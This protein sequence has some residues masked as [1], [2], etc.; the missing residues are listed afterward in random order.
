MIVKQKESE[1]EGI[2]YNCE[3]LEKQITALIEYDNIQSE[4]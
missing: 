1:L 4:I 2:K 3:D